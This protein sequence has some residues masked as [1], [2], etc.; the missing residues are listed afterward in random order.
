MKRILILPLLALIV[1]SCGKDE[2]DDYLRRYQFTDVQRSESGTFV[3]QTDSTLTPIS[4]LTGFY[5]DFVDT[6]PQFIENSQR[7]FLF[8]EEFELFT[9]TRLRISGMADQTPFDTILPYTLVGER[10]VIDAVS[11]YFI[12][13]DVASDEIRICNDVRIAIRGPNPPIT[14]NEYGIVVNTC[15][16]DFDGHLADVLDRAVY[17]AG[18][19]LGLFILE[20]RYK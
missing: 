20:T 16:F 17:V 1:A 9:T 18:D 8:I 10:I 15:E 13:L 7:E 2:G 14:G 3:L 4:G 19:T 5:A 12:R 11:P 6:L